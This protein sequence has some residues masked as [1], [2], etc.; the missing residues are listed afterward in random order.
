VWV[1][2]K[3]SS[4]SNREVLCTP[5]QMSGSGIDPERVTHP[6]LRVYSHELLFMKIRGHLW[7]FMLKEQT[8]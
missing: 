7:T 6:Y 8:A 5:G 3:A 1:A 2:L 4:L